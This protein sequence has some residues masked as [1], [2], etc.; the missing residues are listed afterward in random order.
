MIPPIHLEV[1]EGREELGSGKPE[2]TIWRVCTRARGFTLLFQLSWKFGLKGLSA[3]EGTA[4]WMKRICSRGGLYTLDHFP[5]PMSISALPL[6]HSTSSTKSDRQ[7]GESK[8]VGGALLAGSTCRRCM[9]AIDMDKTDG[10]S[11][12]RKRGG[13]RTCSKIARHTSSG[14]AAGE[15]GERIVYAVDQTRFFSEMEGR[16]RVPRSEFLRMVIETCE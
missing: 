6:A 12:A 10:R 2:K 16:G 1:C 9:T 4:I 3:E 8:R 15:N 11:S 7:G 14:T 5:S 13:S